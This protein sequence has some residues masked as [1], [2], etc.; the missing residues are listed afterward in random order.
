MLRK[1]QIKFVAINMSIVT[2]MLCVILG[3]VMHFTQARLEQGNL[4]MMRNM[5]T[6]NFKPRKPDA[7]LPGPNLPFFIIDGR[8]MEEVAVEGG[9]WFDLSD[10]AL[11]EQLYDEGR[12]APGDSGVIPE[13]KL[14][15]L[16]VK[17]PH[18]ERIVF[19]DI[20]S[21][22]DTMDG[23]RKSCL[24]IGILSFFVF[25]GL[26]I[27]LARWAVGPVAK[28][29]TQQKRFVSD[30]S[31]ELK[32][33]LTVISANA[34][35]LQADCDEACRR[36]LS[37]SIL[38]MSR[39]MKSL[40]ESMLE[41][42]RVDNGA[43]KQNYGRLDL[44]PLVE[45]A[46][47]NFEALF[48]ERGLE[49]VCETEEDIHVRGDAGQLKQLADILLDNAGKYSLSPGTVSLRL[50]KQGRYAQLALSNPAPPM[51]DAALKNIFKRFYRLDDARSR[52]GSFG[53]GLSIAEQIVTGHKGDI[54]AEY[55]E[56]RIYF[57]V[58][59]TLA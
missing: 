37:G 59:L 23:L 54:H 38:T 4:D 44:S 2:V 55:R 14:R 5:A 24:M 36:E 1:L 56:G 28:A 48:Y 9:S 27:L 41:L 46:A 58:R 25:L 8:P 17:L 53:L 49:L 13:Y 42:A 20:S 34:E 7:D 11:V 15:F 30:A 51:D 22:M 3:L 35:L 18:M 19:S 40:V 6:D 29:W 45:T 21:E 26:S 57:I 10:P 33:P 12:S 39:Q 52:D 43:Q 32:T 50:T 47:L 31:H 16:R